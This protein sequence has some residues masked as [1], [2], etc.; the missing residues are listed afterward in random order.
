MILLSFLPLL[1]VLTVAQSDQIATTAATSASASSTA[2]PPSKLLIPP[3]ISLPHIPDNRSITITNSCPDDLWPALLTTNNTGPY[4]SGFYL[5][6]Q[7]SI[8]LWVSHDWIGRIWARTNCSFDE[9]TNTGPCF[10]GSCGNIMNCSIGGQPPTTLAEFNLLGWQNLS[11][12][13]ISLVNGFNLPIAINPYPSGP[14]PICQ[15]APTPQGIKDHCPKEL[16]FY[17]DAPNTYTQIA[18]CMSACDRYRDSKY[19]CTGKKANPK[20]CGPSRYSK[21][22]KAVCPDAY[23]YAY[24]DKTSTFATNTGPEWNYEVVFCP[25]I[26][27]LGFAHYRWGVDT[28]FAWR[29]GKVAS[30]WDD[31]GISWTLHNFDMHWIVS[32]LSLR[33]ALKLE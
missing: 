2:S 15:W 10:T 32:M 16:I 17:A 27:L 23:S 28:Y 33:I 5:P 18:G 12:W 25:G 29:V 20:S 19:C 22:F 6:P 13:D 30:R 7:M 21:S 11:Y 24:D 3:P 26:F 14:K 1:V 8:Q 31:L 9:S 4:Q